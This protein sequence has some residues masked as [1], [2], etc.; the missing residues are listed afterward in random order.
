MKS[1]KRLLEEKRIREEK[2][3]EKERIKAEKLKQKKEEKRLK[4]KKKMKSIQ[5]KKY[6]AKK[7]NAVLEQREKNGDFRS[8]HMVVI[9]KNH[10]K[11]KRIGASWWKADAFEKYNEAVKKNMEEVKF[12]VKFTEVNNEAELTPLKYEIMIV[13]R[14]DEEDNETRLRNENG[15]FV[16]NVIVDNSNYRII[17]KHDWYVEDN[18]NVYGYHPKK[19]RKDFKFIANEMILKDNCI[20]NIKRIFI[21][22]NKLV[23]Q[24]NDDFDFVICKTVKEAERLHDAL[25]KYVGKQKYIFFTGHLNKNLSTEFLN[26]LEE[27]TGWT[28]ETCKRI[29]TL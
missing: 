10:K 22:N 27:K 25:M 29:H 7:R 12:P 13:Q 2:K 5:N 3:A 8:Y 9:M 17:A 16:E 24:Y 19:D 15:E 23:I 1:L 26:K 4:H 6:Y 28:R 11:V 21:Y 14:N 20:E 18:F